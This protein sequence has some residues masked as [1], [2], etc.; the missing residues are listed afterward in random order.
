MIIVLDGERPVSWNTMYSGAHWGK[1]KDRADSAHA[2][3][4]Y[5]LSI[6][7]EP[8]KLFDGRVH[9]T[10][11]AYFKH[12]PLDPCNITA[13]LYIDGLHKIVIEDDTM[14]YVASVTTESHIDKDNPRVEMEIVPEE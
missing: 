9:I 8:V 11:R 5:A 10:V 2:A 4:H 3:V 13:K 1:R 14:E 12:R 6:L 7:E